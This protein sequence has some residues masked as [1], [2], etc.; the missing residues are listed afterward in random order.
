MKRLVLI[1]ACMTLLGGCASFKEAYYLDREYGMASQA[2]W[3]KQVAY[4][5]Y[6]YAAKVPETT[7]G[8]TAEEVMDVYNG[9]FGDV[10][11]EVNIFQMGIEQ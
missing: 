3:D 4:P 11:E 8:I 2:A 10:P 5:D 1:V 9:T 6:R 7:E